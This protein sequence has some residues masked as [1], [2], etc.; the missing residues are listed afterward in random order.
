MLISVPLYLKTTKNVYSGQEHGSRVRKVFFHLE[1]QL[2]E[3]ESSV[4]RHDIPSIYHN[5]W[6]KLFNKCLS[7]EWMVQISI[8]PWWLHWLSLHF[9]IC[10]MEVIVPPSQNF[11]WY[12]L[13]K[14][15]S[16]GLARSTH[17]WCL[18]LLFLEQPVF[19]TFLGT[20]YERVF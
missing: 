20:H 10:R 1:C 8:L 11:L 18:L 16:T 12:R 7:N 13:C 5:A 3:S 6:H 2:C 19:E 14:E 4:I 9:L 17:S 15:L